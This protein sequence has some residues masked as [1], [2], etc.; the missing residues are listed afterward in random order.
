MNGA[1]PMQQLG[2]SINPAALQQQQQQPP[3][4]NLS[5][6]LNVFNLTRDQFQMLSQ[7]E[8]YTLGQRYIQHVNHQNQ[9]QVQPQQAPY[10]RPSSSASNQGPH[11]NAMLPP[12]PPRPPTAQ[13]AP[14]ISRP[15]TSLSHRSPTIP[16]SG[17]SSLMERPQSGLVRCLFLWSECR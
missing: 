3:P 2:G 13:G 10:E 15:G 17:P 9:G 14:Q 6:L 4:L 12:P 1:G 11:Q 16:G 5:H 7:Q 8:R